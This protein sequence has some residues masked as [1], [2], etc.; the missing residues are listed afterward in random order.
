[1]EPSLDT[2]G[3]SLE[4]RVL[5]LEA[6]L[7][8]KDAALREVQH[9]A[10]NGLQLAIS[11]LRLQVG[12][13]RDPEARAAF[14]DT[15]HRIEALTL[16][17]R[18]LHQSGAEADVDLAAYLGELAQI[19]AAP[20]DEVVRG[21]GVEVA[22]AADA[23]AVDLTAAMTI[24]LIV[25]ELILASL[26]HAFSGAPRID[27]A[28]TRFG[29]RHARLTITDNGRPLPSGFDRSEDDAMLL[30]QAL[31]GQLGG[32]IDTDTDGSSIVELIF[33]LGRD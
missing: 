18:Q 32:T 22:V 5:E 20:A 33:P 27:L 21:A 9:R 28:L 14:E 1:M 25:N 16:V 3:H 13:M 17:Y 6:A 31:A 4:A 24:G 26:R 7:R 29:G 11:L 12:R 23:I 10:K 2:H 30:V 8:H 15:L 19:A